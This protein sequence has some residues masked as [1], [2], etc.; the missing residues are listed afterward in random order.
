MSNSELR[1][2][3][4]LVV[5]D[6][7]ENL[8]LMGGL[9]GDLYRVKVANSGSRALKILEGELLPDLI[10]LDVMMPEM[11]G[12]DVCRVIQSTKRLAHIAVIFLT[13]KTSP[14]DEK[15]GFD[16]GA[17]DYIS[18][19]INPATLLARVK[20]H[21]SLK[22]MS[23]V[24]RNRNLVLKDEIDKGV[25][26]IRAIQE[27]TIHAM[28]SL[29][30]TRDNETGNH[31]RR[32][33]NYVKTLAQTLSKHPRFAHYLTDEQIEMLYLSAPLHDI[34]KVGIP[35]HILLKPDRLDA[36]EF[37]IMKT[38]TTLGY[39]SIL[40]A[41]E[42][43]SAGSSFLTCAMEIAL[44][45]QEKWDGSGY[46]QGLSGDAIPISARLMAVADVYDALIS[47]RYYK[48]AF[49]HE[50]A[51]GIILEG[52]GSHFDPDVV[53]AFQRIERKFVEIATKFSD[54]VK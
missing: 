39:Q 23:D 15:L 12:W 19:P 47:E 29:A 8:E 27:T 42:R 35:D 4:V 17:V 13:A 6:S 40:S 46:P 20:T 41:S 11:S 1:D 52:R 16:L 2:S 22:R 38:H 21:L 28:A 9:L 54:S 50:S 30:E 33:Q 34:G 43:L 37:E 26:E 18:K 24:L 51:V 48:K 5:D 31:I 10:L 7:P 49:S 32:T 45:H 14:D 53:D 25:Q 3:T 36:A 44:S